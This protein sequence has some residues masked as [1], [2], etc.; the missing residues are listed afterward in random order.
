MSRKK[1]RTTAIA[2]AL[3]ALLVC[4]CMRNQTGDASLEQVFLDLTQAGEAEES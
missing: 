3:L 2:F 4:G 1:K